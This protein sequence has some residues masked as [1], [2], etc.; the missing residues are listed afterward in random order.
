MVEGIVC[1]C[2]E[3]YRAVGKEGFARSR[4]NEGRREAV[5][6]VGAL[7]TIAI[8]CGYHL[9]R[10]LGPGLFESVYETLLADAISRRGVIVETQKLIDNDFD[11]LHIPN[12]FKVDLL[13]VGSLLI[14]LKSVERASPVHIKQTLTYLRLMDLPLGLVMNFGEA[15]FRD[16][17]K[18]V[19]NTFSGFPASSRLRANP[20]SPASEDQC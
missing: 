9:H 1:V 20:F 8:D 19:V 3:R 2:G 18:R 4:E 17:L 14:E 5:G 10:R 7:A 11:G 13:L 15:Q 16:G 12:A 6:D